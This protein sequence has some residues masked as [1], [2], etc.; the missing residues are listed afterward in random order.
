MTGF[1]GAVPESPP[2]PQAVKNKVHAA[3]IIDDENLPSVYLRPKVLSDVPPPAP[4]HLLRIQFST[5]YDL[6]LSNDIAA[7]MSDKAT[8]ENYP[9]NLKASGG[10]DELQVQRLQAHAGQS[11]IGRRL[12]QLF[13]HQGRHKAS[14]LTLC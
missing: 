5:L 4:E 13:D 2:P 3:V 1:W 6:C 9:A 7:L 12:L 14:H 8:F 10:P 11:R